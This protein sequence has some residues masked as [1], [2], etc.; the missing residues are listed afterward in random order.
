[1]ATIPAEQQ[2]EFSSGYP[3]AETAEALHDQNRRLFGGIAVMLASLAITCT[4]SID[5]SGPAP[6]ESLGM[7][8]GLSA[9]KNLR[10]LGGYQT[11][12]GQTVVRGLVYRS[13][14]FN[15]M[16]DDDRVKL[17][18]IGVKRD[19]DLRT[20]AELEKQP[21]QVPP[22]MEYVHL[23]VLAD[24]STAAPAQLEALLRDP[25]KA[26]TALGGG[27]LDALFTGE[28]RKFVSLPSA[29]RAYRELFLSLSD[30]SKL[31]AVFHCTTGK[32]RTG[33]AAAA[34]LT[35]LG[36]PRETVFDDYLRTNDYLLPYYAKHI[37]AFAAAG[38][39]RAILTAILGVKREYLEASFDEMQQR[40]GTI[41]RYFAEALGIDS[42][43]QAVMR[44]L[45]LETTEASRQTMSTT[46]NND[47]ERVAS[48][49]D[50]VDFCARVLAIS[51]RQGVID[52]RG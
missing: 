35:L 43:A 47:V 37:D 5:I 20:T 8:L 24:E 6:G 2:Y 11:A 15:P 46:Q 23:D 32:D 27:K 39:D 49:T 26:T 52:R 1:M 12:D 29:R 14:V 42:A 31:P 28:Y 7:A 40:Y 44:S 36:V 41:E 17:Q 9:A 21:D 25:P 51:V 19:Y 18:R 33:W 45:Y 48:F 10:D 38:G 3:T 30:R 50:I 22:T 16:S 4:P 34:L 13:D